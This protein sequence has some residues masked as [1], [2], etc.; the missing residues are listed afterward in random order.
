M[1]VKTWRVHLLF[2]RNTL[3]VFRVSNTQVGIFLSILLA[4]DCMY[5]YSFFFIENIIF[6]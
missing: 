1:L 3:E 5:I 6:F 4:V 2:S